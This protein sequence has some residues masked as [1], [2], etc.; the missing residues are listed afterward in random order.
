MEIKYTNHLK[1]R[2]QLRQIEYDL[3]KRVYSES[4]ERYYDTE[5]GHHIALLAVEI[6]GKTR[7]VIAVYR[8]ESENVLILTIHPL[9]EG[10]KETRIQNG[11]WR[12]AE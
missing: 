7:D 6:Y 10:Q 8:A 4:K 2:L 5:T 11:R 3:P 9:K 12:K 1:N